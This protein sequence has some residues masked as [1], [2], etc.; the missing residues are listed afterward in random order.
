MHYRRVQRRGAHYQCTRCDE[1]VLWR[2][3]APEWNEPPGEDREALE[4][5]LHYLRQGTKPRNGAHAP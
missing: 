2:D 5:R 1:F 3:G 4:R